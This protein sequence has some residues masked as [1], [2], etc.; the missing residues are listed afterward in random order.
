MFAFL[1]VI[2]AVSYVVT[3]FMFLDATTSANPIRFLGVPTW[4]LLAVAATVGAGVIDRLNQIRDRLMRN[5]A[6]PA[7]TMHDVPSLNAIVPDTPPQS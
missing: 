2:A 5:S 7:H 1:W 6:A 3:F 4:G